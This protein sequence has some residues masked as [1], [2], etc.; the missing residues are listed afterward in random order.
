MN[1]NLTDITVLLDR[2]GSMARVKD[3]VIG[4][5]NEFVRKQRSATDEARLT[6][7]Q[8]DSEDSHELVHNGIDIHRVPDLTPETYQPRA[9]TPLIDALGHTIV[10]TGE[11]LK[12]IPEAE[13]PGKVVVLV[14]TDGEENS[15]QEYTNERVKAMVEHQQTVYKWQ[16]VFIGADIDAFATAGGLAIPGAT[17][18]RSDKM[19]LRQAWGL[20][21]DNIAKFR[22]SALAVDLAYSPAQRDALKTDVPN[23]VWTKWRKT[24]GR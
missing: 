1:Q 16:F 8:F 18:L 4:G 6:L 15:S 23:D 21:S 2:T 19:K 7:V 3:D 14:I 13:R 9:N 11:R 24:G 22:K 12:A 20:T 5:F 10:S 17:T